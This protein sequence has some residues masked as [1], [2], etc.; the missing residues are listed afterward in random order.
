MKILVATKNPGKLKEMGQYLGEGFELVSL[1][2]LGNAPEVS[3]NALTFDANAVAKARAYFEWSGL[4]TIAED[5]GFEID[6][7]GGEPGVY[8]RRWPTADELA[9][10]QLR[11]KTDEE[12]IALA[13]AK[14]Q[15]VPPDQRTARLRSVGVFYDGART[16]VEMAAVEGVITQEYPT[17]WPQGLPFRGIFL[18]PQFNKLYADLTDQEH[19]QVNQRRPVYTRLR[20]R[21]LH[22]NA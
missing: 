19:E 20:T 10:G 22:D 18:I 9:S 14:L 17:R 12:L 13:L 4:P 1:A 6:A 2:D 11:E 8:S 15:G 16:F 5:G 21:I 7:L 3:E